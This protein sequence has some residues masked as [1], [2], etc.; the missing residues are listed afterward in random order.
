MTALFE[1]TPVIMALDS[2]LSTQ[3]PAVDITPILLATSIATRQLQTDRRRSTLSDIDATL[4]C[5]RILEEKIANLRRK[6][7][8]WRANILQSLS[9]ISALPGELLGI[10][11]NT[12]AEEDHWEKRWQVGINL[13]HVCSRWR[14]VTLGL[15]ELW[16][17]LKIISRAQWELMP[18]FGQRSRNSR[19]HIQLG[20]HAP[21]HSP[22]IP[23]LE[24]G[25]GEAR[26]ICSISFYDLQ[27]FFAFNVTPDA[28]ALLD[29][30]KALFVFHNQSFQIP[31]YLMTVQTVSLLRGS[32]ERSDTHP[33]SAQG[34][35][36]RRRQGRCP[37]RD[38]ALY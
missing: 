35:A 31:R 10:I 7:E 25:A 5:V 8:M 4:A 15:G 33:T 18:L 21:G 3:S 17:Q 38:A 34:T 9:P 32:C 14:V 37:N 36:D 16:S 13:S 19:L 26:Q 6:L 22:F 2:L 29:L 28:L 30:E 12:V 27:T 24:V 11:F 1:F 20:D 23:G